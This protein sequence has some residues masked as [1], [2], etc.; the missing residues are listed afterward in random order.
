MGSD[1]AWIFVDGKL[2]IDLG[3]IVPGTEQI[4]EMDRLGLEDGLFYEVRLFYANRHAGAANFDM[5]TNLELLTEQ[6]V[7]QV[8]WPCD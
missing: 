5:L 2:G 1:D 7:V 6:V 4:L 8:T 3:G